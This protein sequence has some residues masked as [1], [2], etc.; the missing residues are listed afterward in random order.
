MLAHLETYLNS[1]YKLYELSQVQGVW[2]SLN[3]FEYK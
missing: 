3:T 1:I 2:Y